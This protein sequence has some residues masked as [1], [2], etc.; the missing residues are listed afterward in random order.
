M[1]QEQN[2]PLPQVYLV[3]GGGGLQHPPHQPNLVPCWSFPPP[4][5]RQRSREKSGGCMGVRPGVALLVLM[6]FLLVF[7]ALGFEAFQIHRLQRELKELRQAEPEPESHSALKQIGPSEAARRGEDR[8]A[9]AHV[10]GRIEGAVFPQTLRWDPHAGRGFTSGGVS[11]RYED[12][13]LQVNETGLYHIY[14]RV[15]LTFK[16]C[17]PESSF[18][19]TM[20]VRRGGRSTPLRLMEAHRAGFCHLRTKLSWTTESYLGSA[21]QLQ[22]HDRVYVNVSRPSDLRRVSYANFFGLYK[23]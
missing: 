13:A 6:L 5:V 7:A 21:Q 8:P 15:E 2:Y 3:D 18:L 20:F 9:A 22:R 19:H 1:N 10:T 11:Y 17:S 23:I 12:G 4:Q 14:S 16:D